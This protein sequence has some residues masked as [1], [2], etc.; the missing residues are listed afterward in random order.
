MPKI[1]N[2]GHS[3]RSNGEF[4]NLLKINCVEILVDVR[5]FPTSKYDAFKKDNLS[6]SLRDA[7]I[8]YLYSG[9]KLGG[10]RTGGYKAYVETE[11]FK[12]ALRELEI[13]AGNNSVCFM[14]AEKKPQFCH[15]KF[16]AEAF[17]CRGW[18]VVDI[19]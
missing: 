5:R 7:D 12:K 3:N 9:G 14:C 11:D 10:F 16:I 17:S 2:I 19:V 13:I 18:E 1:F 8:Q 15:R 4:I 6:K